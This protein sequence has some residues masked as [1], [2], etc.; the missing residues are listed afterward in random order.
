MA[1][2][3]V[4]GAPGSRTRLNLTE[5]AILVEM[6]VK[7]ERLLEKRRGLGRNAISCS[8][9]YLRAAGCRDENNFVLFRRCH[10]QS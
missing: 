2:P 5:R 10:S 1:P 3:A 6:F 9:R 4:S 7:Q 8:K